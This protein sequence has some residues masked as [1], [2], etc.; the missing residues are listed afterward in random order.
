MEEY[1]TRRLLEVNQEFYRRFASSFASTRV[2][3]QPGFSMLLDLFPQ[4]SF[5]ILDVGCGEGRFGRYLLEQQQVRTYTGV[6]FTEEL[7][8]IASA[9][10][11]GMYFIRDLSQS[12]CLDGLGHF[13][14]IA[15]MATLQHIPGRINRKRLVKELALHLS[16]DGL[17]ALSNWQF[18]DSQRQMKKVKDWS[19]VGLTS[20][21]VEENDYLLTW[22]R[23]GEGLRYV[24]YIDLSEMESLAQEVGLKIIQH[25][26]S[27]GREGNLNQYTILSK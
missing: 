18:M 13:D 5:D 22:N 16:Q 12:G 3:P 8:A 24:S 27:D 7:L 17:L 1:V 11:D 23:D 14:L 2:N 25:F 21:D 26:R 20:D 4:S 15:C 9:K 10:I 6:D 19:A